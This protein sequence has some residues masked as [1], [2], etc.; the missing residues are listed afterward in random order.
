MNRWP[1]LSL[2]R[3]DFPACR[4]GRSQLVQHLHQILEERV[5][6]GF[7][8]VEDIGE[9]LESFVGAV[10]GGGAVV[11]NI[12]DELEAKGTRLNISGS[13]HDPTGPTGKLFFGMLALMAEFESHLIRAHTREGIAEAKKASRLKGKQPKLSVLQR[14]RLL[15]DY[16]SGEYTAV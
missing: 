7:D 16:E 10:S 1:Q 4:I 5:G 13:V 11:V 6:T 14:K 9:V 15:A 8:L 12:A 3:R 2:T